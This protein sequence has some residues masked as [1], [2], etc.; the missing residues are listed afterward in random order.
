[1]CNKFNFLSNMKNTTARR[2]QKVMFLR[3]FPN[4]YH[5]QKCI[6]NCKSTVPFQGFMKALSVGILPA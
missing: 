5:H 2:Q 6:I 1:M 3:Y 4:S